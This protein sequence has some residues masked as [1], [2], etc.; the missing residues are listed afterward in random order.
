LMTITTPLHS[1]GVSLTIVL[2]EMR[3]V[4]MLSRTAAAPAVAL[5]AAIALTG[6]S[7]ADRAAPE[8]VTSIYP[9]QYVVERIVDGRLDVVNLTEPGQESHDFEMGIEQTAMLSEAGTVVYLPE[10]QPAVD[11]AVVQQEPG[12]VLEVTDYVDLRP[13]EGH[14]HEED[15]EP[16]FWL[17]PTR[18]ADVA[19]AVGSSLSELHPEHADEFEAN[20]EALTDDLTAVDADYRAGLAGCERNEV[21]VGHDAFGYLERYGLELHPIAGLSPGAEPSPAR[22]AELSE[23][24]EETGVTTVFSEVLA[25][26]ALAETL[27][28]E[29]GLRTAVLDPIEGLAEETEDE[30]YVS[31][32]RKN[33]AAL[34]EANGCR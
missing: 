31:L 14:A 16:H 22:L 1:T 4:V 13:V 9:L 3:M 28:E 29:L 33:L 12:H 18:M 19:A 20:L 7:D 26:P 21:V 30:D 5:C 32:M 17:D 6:C 11:E 2:S 15:H 34:Q 10:F 8:V 24:I 27:S 25:S 23:V